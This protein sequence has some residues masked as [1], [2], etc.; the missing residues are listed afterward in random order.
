MPSYSEK[1]LKKLLE[2]F[3]AFQGKLHEDEVYNALQAILN[4]A[5]GNLKEAGKVSQL[6][7]WDFFNKGAQNI[8]LLAATI[9]H[10]QVVKH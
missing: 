2:Q 3:S 7:Y 10:D 9:S 5:K 1:A 8:F 4:K 6:L